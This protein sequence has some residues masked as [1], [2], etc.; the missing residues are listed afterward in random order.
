M[1]WAG[2]S[3][4]E[5]SWEV[6]EAMLQQFPDCHL[7]DKVIL[8]WGGVLVNPQPDLLMPGEL[9]NEELDIRVKGVFP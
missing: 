3:E 9:V 4:F 5:A 2:M 7:E 1:K 8:F 6:F